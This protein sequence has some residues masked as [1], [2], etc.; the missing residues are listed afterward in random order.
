MDSDGARGGERDR[1]DAEL[2]F[3]GVERQAEL[4]RTGKITSRALVE[5][6]LRR[7]TRLDPALGAF[8]VVLA[9]GPRRGRRPGRGR[10][11]APS[12]ACP[13]PSRT[14]WTSPGR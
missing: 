3:Q 7:I 13:S 14:S 4:V 2:I 5:A 12:T 11:T 9:S 1:E 6:A 10:R 8:R